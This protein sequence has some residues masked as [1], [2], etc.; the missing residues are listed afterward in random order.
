M[1]EELESYT[2]DE[3]NASMQY[4]NDMN[5]VSQ[6]S[7]IYD[8]KNLN[9]GV[10]PFSVDN[11]LE[12]ESCMVCSNKES[13]L[14]P[15]SMPHEFIQSNVHEVLVEVCVLENKVFNSWI[16]IVPLQTIVHEETQK[17]INNKEVTSDK[18]IDQP[19]GESSLCKESASFEEL[20]SE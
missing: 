19:Y 17:F 3:E 7:V 11:A 18:Y 12:M 6:I 20:G 8:N 9:D 15:I 4:F 2:S 16:P 1:C 13:M 10:P 5:L 14:Q